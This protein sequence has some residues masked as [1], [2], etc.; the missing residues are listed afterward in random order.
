MPHLQANVDGGQCKNSPSITV[1][2]SGH[3]ATHLGHCATDFR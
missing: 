3:C 1:G 2:H